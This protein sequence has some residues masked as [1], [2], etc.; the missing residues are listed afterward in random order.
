MEH[1]TDERLSEIVSEAEALGT[2]ALSHGELV[3]LARSLM[4]ERA[5]VAR[6]EAMVEAQDENLR[7]ERQAHEA[8]VARLSSELDDVRNELI[9]MAKEIEELEEVSKYYGAMR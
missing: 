2:A 4:I 7:D 1:L 3:I 6:L 5:K 9:V 8:I